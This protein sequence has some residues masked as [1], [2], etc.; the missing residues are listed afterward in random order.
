MGRRRLTVGVSPFCCVAAD[1]TSA[2][3]AYRDVQPEVEAASGGCDSLAGWLRYNATGRYLPV[4]CRV[5]VL[6][7]I[8]LSAARRNALLTMTDRRPPPSS[9]G[10]NTLSV[11]SR[12]VTMHR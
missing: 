11:L 1:S 9:N 7:V 6:S 10:R 5:I 3:A 8:L 12:L 4:I 2:S